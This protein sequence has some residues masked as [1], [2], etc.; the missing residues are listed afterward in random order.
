MITKDLISCRAVRAMNETL[1]QNRLLREQGDDRPFSHSP[2][3][4]SVGYLQNNVCLHYCGNTRLC[5]YLYLCLPV[6]LSAPHE[7]HSLYC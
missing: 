7:N 2:N 5:Y 1:K 4:S 3:D 6:P